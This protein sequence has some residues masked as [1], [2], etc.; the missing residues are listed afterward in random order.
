M[1]IWLF[2]IT[3]EKNLEQQ[4]MMTDDN[5]HKQRQWHEGDTDAVIQ[6]DRQEDLET[7]WREDMG[8]GRS[9]SNDYI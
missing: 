8:A 3:A 4:E 9:M 5:E 2:I 1:C 6:D 7:K